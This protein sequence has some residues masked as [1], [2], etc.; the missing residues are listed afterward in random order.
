VDKYKVCPTCGERNSPSVLECVKDS[1]DLTGVKIVDELMESASVEQRIPESKTNKLVRIC[2]CGTVNVASSR[3]CSS[4][5]E[6]I[7]DIQLT[8]DN[9]ITTLFLYSIDGIYSIKIDEPLVL[10]GREQSMKEYLSDKAYV[11]RTHAKLTKV[12][13][14][15]YITNL[16]TSNG[17]YV[18]NERISG[19]TPRLLR[20][21][22]EI[23]LGGLQI[24]EKRQ[25]QAAY[26]VVRSGTC[27]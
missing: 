16:S 7:S 26:F 4:C 6:D 10:I 22:D 18:N 3:K 2:D 5:E 1:T 9:T 20:N 8:S 21:G 19:D 15:I 17:T 12:G 24:N 27:T 25:D 11:S 13:C 23:G 14:D